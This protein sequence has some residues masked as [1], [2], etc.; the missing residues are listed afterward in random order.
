MSSNMKFL[1]I[2]LIGFIPLAAS[3]E[4]VISLTE[5]ELSDKVSEINMAQNNVIMLGSSKT[6]VDNLFLAGDWVKLDQPAMLMEAATTSAL[7]C[8]NNIFSN[9]G[10]KQEQIYSVPLKGIFA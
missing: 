10:L 3:A 9:E 4:Q 5:K 8:A 6:E 7:Y 1:A 2:L